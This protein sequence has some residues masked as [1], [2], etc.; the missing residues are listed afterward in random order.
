MRRRE[1]GPA[2]PAGAAD[3]R[4]AVEVMRKITCNDAHGVLLGA[5][6][7]SSQWLIC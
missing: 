3:L 5:M 4:L 6:L 2:P 7:R 1:A